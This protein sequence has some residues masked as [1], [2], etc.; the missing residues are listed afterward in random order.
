MRCPHCG[1]TISAVLYRCG[2]CGMVLPPPAGS[3]PVGPVQPSLDVDPPAIRSLDGLGSAAMALIWLATLLY[4]CFLVPLIR[5]TVTGT[6]LAANGDPAP[7]LLITG[8][9]YLASFVAA[10]ATFVTWLFIARRNLNAIAEAAPAWGEPWT[11]TAWSLPLFASAAMILVAL[12][13]PGVIVVTSFWFVLVPFIPLL[14]WLVGA[15]VVADV[16]R[17]SV[18]GYA[19][20]EGARY[21]AKAWWWWTFYVA[22]F[23][24]PALGLYATAWTGFGGWE[25]IEGSFYLTP[26]GVGLILG[27]ISGLAAASRITSIV[28]WVGGEH[29]QRLQRRWD[30]AQVRTGETTS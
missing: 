25:I 2:H 24:L 27:A 19:K 30:P 16:A 20:A 15:S 28:S 4:V 18:D 9:L 3:A 29:R 12:L 11:I 22:A 13:D 10:A 17:N 26:S 6:T 7:Y 8:S 23:L 21:A 5:T 14:S 1:A